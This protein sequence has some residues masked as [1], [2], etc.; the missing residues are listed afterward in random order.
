MISDLIESDDDLL[1]DGA[2]GSQ[3]PN[4]SHPRSQ[5][6]RRESPAGTSTVSNFRQDGNPG[7]KPIPQKGKALDKR[8]RPRSLNCQEQVC[9]I[10]RKCLFQD[11]KIHLLSS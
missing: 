3:L 8:P 5:F 1:T 2:G 9:L 7:R 11:F 10:L 6:R 4:K